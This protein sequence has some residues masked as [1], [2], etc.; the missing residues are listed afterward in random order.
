MIPKSIK[1]FNQ[2]IKIVFK[3]TLLD[4]KEPCFGT[5]HYKR[6]TIYLQKSTRKHTLTEEQIES[7]F[8]HELLHACLDL[9]GE[10]ELND[11][12]KFVSS[13]SHLIYQFIKQLSEKK[14]IQ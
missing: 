2:T 10:H 14:N 12:E 11:N 3:R 4:G 7:T 5:W 6:N 8:I 13:L 9:M 1:I